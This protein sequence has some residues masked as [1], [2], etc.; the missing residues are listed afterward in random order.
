MGRRDDFADATDP[1]I[2]TA[3]LM[4][5]AN[6]PWW[7]VRARVASNPRLPVY[8]LY[9]LG[10]DSHLEVSVAA[11]LAVS[12]GSEEAIRAG[13]KHDPTLTRAVLHACT[14]FDPTTGSYVI[15]Q[16]DFDIVLRALHVLTPEQSVA[17]VPREW[18]LTVAAV[19]CATAVSPPESFAPR[20]SAPAP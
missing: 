19:E 7:E 10:V 5:L 2:S 1:G 3:R 14:A 16:A 15:S 4:A 9:R 17:D 8:A 13:L 18:V 6:S 12:Q 20:Q 11:C